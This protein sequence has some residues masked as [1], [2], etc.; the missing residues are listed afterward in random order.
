MSNIQKAV[1]A[2]SNANFLMICAGAGI[3]VDSGLPDFRGNEGFWKA[4]PPIRKLGLSLPEVSN[5]RWFYED[6]RFAWGFYGHRYHLYLLDN[7][8]VTLQKC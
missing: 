6:P 1:Q 7:H 5:P 2:I 8:D 3:G 4:Y